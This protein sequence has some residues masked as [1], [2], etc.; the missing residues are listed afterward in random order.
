MMSADGFGQVRAVDVRELWQHEERDFTPWL[1]NNKDRLEA[2]LGLDIELDAREHAVG[3]FELDLIG[4]DTSDGSPIIIENQLAG[5][6]HRHLGQLLTYAGGV[7]AS[8]VIW[9]ATSFTEPH[10][11]AMEWLNAHTVET[12]SFFAIE[13]RAIRIDDSRPAPIFDVVVRPNDWER[14]VATVRSA[15]LSERQELFVAFWAAFL[16]VARDRGWTA[17]RSPQPQQWTATP[18]GISGLTINGSFGR[19]GLSAELYFQHP[20]ADRNLSR[21]RSLLA[22]QDRFEASYGGALDWQE[23]EGRRACRI[24]D[25][26]PDASIEDRDHWDGCLAWLVDRHGRLRTALDALGG[27][28]VAVGEN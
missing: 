11:S 8:T 28:A 1:L 2:A 10:R 22:Q 7:E 18:S 17:A 21:F 14:R 12:V 25:Y 6:D 3:G 23:L 20:D 24:A 4:R 13:L 16:A 26:L 5:S 9:I 15:G 19:R 27:T